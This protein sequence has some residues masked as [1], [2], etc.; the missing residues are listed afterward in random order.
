MGREA[1]ITAETWQRLRALDARCSTSMT[2]EHQRWTVLLTARDIAPWRD[3]TGEGP[4]LEAALVAVIAEC[5][6]RNW[7]QRKFTI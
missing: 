6:R 5:E 4:D 1:P 7:H 3:V 2:W